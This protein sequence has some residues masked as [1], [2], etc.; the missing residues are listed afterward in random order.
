MC[1]NPDPNN[2]DDTS[3]AFSPTSSTSGLIGSRFT[4]V[5]SHITDICGFP[6]GSVMVKVIKQEDIADITMMTLKDVDD[7]KVVNSDGSYKTKPLAFHLRCLKD[8]LLFY[9]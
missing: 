7:L 3:T 5:I 6:A 1:G 4:T 9:N 2:P 8:F